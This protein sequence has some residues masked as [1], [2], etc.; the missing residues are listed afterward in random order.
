MMST[1]V[2][3]GGR[4]EGAVAR[5]QAIPDVGGPGA[6]STRLAQRQ[7]LGEGGARDGAETLETAAVGQVWGAK[8]D[9]RRR[10][11]QGE[12]QVE[13]ERAGGRW[14]SREQRVPRPPPEQGAP[15][16]ATA[17]GRGF[18][19]RGGDRPW[20]RRP[21]PPRTRPRLPV[22]EGAPAVDRKHCGR[23]TTFVGCAAECRGP[24][25]FYDHEWP[26][27][28][29]LLPFHGLEREGTRTRELVHKVAAVTSSGTASRRRSTCVKRE[30]RREEVTAEGRDGGE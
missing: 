14:W 16:I 19:R 17:A 23:Q 28:A 3:V 27:G 13:G 30:A 21:P 18:C 7:R 10:R 6:E 8:G 22:A 15:S 9:R 26:A 29:R 25:L 12:R 1:R 11:R 5:A 24:T 20:E 4:G 2:D